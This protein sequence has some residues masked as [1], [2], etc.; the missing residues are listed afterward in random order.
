MNRDKIR[1]LQQFIKRYKFSLIFISGGDQSRLGD[2]FIGSKGEDTPALQSI[3][4]VYAS[5]GTIAGTSAGAAVMSDPMIT[6][7]TSLVSLTGSGPVNGSTDVNSEHLSTRK[8]FG[9]IPG[10][11]VG[12]LVTILVSRLTSPPE[13]AEQEMASVKKVVGRPLRG[14]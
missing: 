6:S 2:I 3:R 14:N 4:Q 10:F 11:L 13:G 7:G 9:L 8:G 12:L 5:G 1:I